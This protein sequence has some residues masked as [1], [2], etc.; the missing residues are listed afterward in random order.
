[1][2]MEGI[3]GADGEQR[4]EMDVGV[5]FESMLIISDN[6]RGITVLAIASS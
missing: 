1:M 3:T 6:L 4:R 2:T 5:V